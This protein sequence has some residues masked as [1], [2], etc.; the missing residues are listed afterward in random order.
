MDDDLVTDLM[1]PKFLSNKTFK[2]RIPDYIDL[3][4]SSLIGFTT[5][6]NE[7]MV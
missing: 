3:E 4:E 2:V 7:V 6:F 1:T 5:W